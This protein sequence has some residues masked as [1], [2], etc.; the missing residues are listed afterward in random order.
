MRRSTV[1]TFAVNALLLCGCSP[2]NGDSSGRSQSAPAGALQSVFTDLGGGSCRKEID[3]S[4]PNDTPYLLCPGVAG[5]A[6]AVRPVDA[7]RV[8]IDVVDATQHVFPLDYHEVVTRAMFTLSDKAEWRVATTDGK[9][10]PVA[11]VVGVLA[12]EDA[13]DP[14]KATHTYIA[15]A[16]ISP[17]GACVTDRIPNDSRSA[18]EV[19][20][21][22]DAA[23]QKECVKPQPPMIRDGAV[24]R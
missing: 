18:D 16:K 24:V 12:H 2:T 17:N 13:G 4:D 14:A 10:L 20:K 21:A 11:L 19:R 7:G 9:Q 5:Y 23:P 3:R 1:A 15:V 8:S 22:A 6:L